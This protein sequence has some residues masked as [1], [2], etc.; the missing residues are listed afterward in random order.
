MTARCSMKPR[1]SQ[2]TLSGWRVR[3]SRHDRV[4]VGSRR[5]DGTQVAD[6]LLTNLFTRTAPLA[7]KPRNAENDPPRSLLG[8]YNG[9][10]S[11][12]PKGTHRCICWQLSLTRTLGDD[13]SVIAQTLLAAA[14]SLV[15]TGCHP[16]HRPS[17]I[18]ALFQYVSPK[19]LGCVASYLIRRIRFGDYLP[20]RPTMFH[21]SAYRD[22]TIN[23]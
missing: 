17:E 4:G 3:T 7:A 13:S 15:P 19:N 8:H 10:P 20:F 5:Y 18:P 9:P 16:D 6:I 11:P 22:Q 14:P 12:A 23:D 2:C 21:R 1:I